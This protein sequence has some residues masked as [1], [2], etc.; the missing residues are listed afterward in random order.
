MFAIFGDSHFTWESIV[1]HGIALYLMVSYGIAWYCVV[2]HG[3]KWYG[4]VL[5]GIACHCM[6]KHIFALKSDFDYMHRLL[7]SLFRISRHLK[8]EKTCHILK[9]VKYP[10]FD[11]FE[12]K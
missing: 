12:S 2:I 3:I 7:I 8:L 9:G 5:Y 6:V 4:M 10:N 11:T 1:L